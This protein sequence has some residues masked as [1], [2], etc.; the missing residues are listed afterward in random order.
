MGAVA[1]P[2]FHGRQL[3]RRLRELREELGHTQEQVGDALHMTLQKMSRIESGQVPAITSCGP[4]WTG[5]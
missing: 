2:N 4:C 5:T 1:T 3:T